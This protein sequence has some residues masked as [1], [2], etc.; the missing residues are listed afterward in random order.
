MISHLQPSGQRRVFRRHQYLVHENEMPD[1]VLRIDGGWACRFC[2]LLD[3]RRQITALYLPGDLCEPQWALGYRPSQPVRALTT[4]RATPLSLRP[5]TSHPEEMERNLW[6][7]MAQTLERQAEWLV[8]L[9]RKTASE[10]VAS[11]LCDVYER[12]AR[13]GQTHAQQCAMPL[14]QIDIADLTG[15]TPVH[16]N[17]TLKLLRARGLID[18][19][20]RWLRIAD[21]PG[22]RT[23]ALYGPDGDASCGAEA[24][25]ARRKRRA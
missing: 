1:A 25:E 22:L 17:R 13:F 18:L 5:R 23:M 11:L 8:S 24:G 4:V 21:L 2:L 9:G 19:R 20:S 12:M 14:T 15:L 3:G 10:R 16:V 6:A 7:S